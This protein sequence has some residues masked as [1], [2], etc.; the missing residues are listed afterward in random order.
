MAASALALAA[1]VAQAA[2]PPT[3]ARSANPRVVMVV[4]NRGAITI[5]LLPKAAPKTVAHFLDL[6]HR[7]F[8]DG[9]LFHRVMPGFVAQAGDPKT[10]G[11]DSAKIAGL[12]PNNSGYGSGGSGKT[13]PLEAKAPHDRG[14]L[15]LA[16]SND[17]NSGDSQFFLNL[18]PNHS[19]DD[20]YC[21]FGKVADAKGLAVMDRI[22]MGD[23]IV[24][25]RVASSKTAGK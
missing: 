19:L 9:I 17:P 4:A 3:P 5:E 13:V 23:K 16:R 2:K 22:R 24:S 14:T 15:G 25:I 12:D 18:V 20:N 11:V 8:Y 6:V 7:K 21:V 10:R 1:P